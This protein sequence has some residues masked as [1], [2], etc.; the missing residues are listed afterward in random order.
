MSQSLGPS[1]TSGPAPRRRRWLLPALTAVFIAVPLAEVWLLLQVGELLGLWPTIGLLVVA[2]VLGSW[3]SKREGTKAWR[4]LQTAMQSGRMPQGELADA[5][6]VLTGGV[7]LVFPG[8]FTDIIGMF[9]LVPFTRP[10][11]R[12][13]LGWVLKAQL[14][15]VA[16]SG[17]MGPM[18]MGPLGPLGTTTSR[19]PAEGNVTIIDGEVVEDP[20]RRRD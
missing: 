7:M 13:L 9:F 19:P 15:R 5:A 6:L 11:A 12:R 1:G 17:P 3:L 20:E 8:F 14:D 10:L 16:K 18:G 4:A 2:A